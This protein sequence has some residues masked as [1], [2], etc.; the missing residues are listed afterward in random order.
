MIEA[1]DGEDIMNHCGTQLIETGRLVLRQ[2]SIDDAQAMYQNWASDPEVVKYLT[3][4]AHSSI[5]V[6]K[7]IIEDWISGP[8]S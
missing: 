3:W 1:D 8:L 2:F 6:T 4:P 5:D 7:A